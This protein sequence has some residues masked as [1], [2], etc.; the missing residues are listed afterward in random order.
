VTMVRVAQHALLQECQG[1]RDHEAYRALFPKGQKPLVKGQATRR[2]E[3][4]ASL[5][6]QLQADPAHSELAK[7]FGDAVAA[8]TAARDAHV[9]ARSCEALA[10]RALDQAR[11]DWTLDYMGSRSQAAARLRSLD[12]AKAFFPA[13]RKKADDG[14][15]GEEPVMEAAGQV[16]P[17]TGTSTG[18]AKAPISPATPTV[19]AAPSKGNGTPEPAVHPPGGEPPIPPAQDLKV[20]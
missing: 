11:V 9:A 6:T 2:M 10:V 17:A 14:A 20:A 7:R 12:A 13:S 8:W 16:I 5:A 18:D 3:A 4:L 19:P 15:D 1:T